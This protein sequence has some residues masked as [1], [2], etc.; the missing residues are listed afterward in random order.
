MKNIG[1]VQL[2]K[3]ELFPFETFMTPILTNNRKTQY[4][5]KSKGVTCFEN[6]EVWLAFIKIG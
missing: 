6:L 5:S 4:S 1:N 3:A 2:N